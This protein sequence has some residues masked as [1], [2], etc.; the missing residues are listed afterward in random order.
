VLTD[1]R[2]RIT[3][4][5][6]NRPEAR[7]ALSGA[8]LRD[9]RAAI[10]AAVG[11]QP[12]TVTRNVSDVQALAGC[13]IMRRR[14]PGNR[15]PDLPAGDG[16]ADYGPRAR[17]ASLSGWHAFRTSWA[18][19]ALASGIPVEIVAAVTGHAQVETVTKHY[20]RPGR[21]NLREAVAAPMGRALAPGGEADTP[22][23]VA[24][25]LARVR[26]IAGSM[27]SRTWKQAR[28]ALLTL[29]ED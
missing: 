10:R 22:R 23:T 1:T 20:W 3:T 14:P 12:S 7:N 27:D 24:D 6:L 9:L 26:D 5:T 11:C 2:D 21:A 18:T 29:A 15:S 25:V 28:A 16:R 4:V 17:R 8:L 19:I 13:R